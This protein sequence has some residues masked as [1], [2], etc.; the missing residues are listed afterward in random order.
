ML[1]GYI[2]SKH[3]IFSD[4]F[5][6]TVNECSLLNCSGMAG[7]LGP[8]TQHTA[9]SHCIQQLYGH[10]FELVINRLD[11]QLKPFYLNISFI[12]MYKEFI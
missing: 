4:G 12:N 7:L 2:F 9:V 5:C 10:F 6:S 3:V 8:Y 1:Y 11:L